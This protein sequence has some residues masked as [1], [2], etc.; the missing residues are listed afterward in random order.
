MCVC[1]CVLSTCIFNTL[2]PCAVHFTYPSQESAPRRV[3]SILPP[4]FIP[5]SSTDGKKVIYGHCTSNKY[6][7]LKGSS[8]AKTVHVQHTSTSIATGC[9]V[10]GKPPMFGYL[11]A[12]PASR[13]LLRGG[14][15][16][17]HALERRVLW[18]LRCVNCVYLPNCYRC[19]AKCNRILP[20][21]LPPGRHKAHTYIVL[22]V[23]YKPSPPPF[24]A[25]SARPLSRALHYHRTVANQLLRRHC[26]RR[27]RCA[28]RPLRPICVRWGNPR[29]TCSPRYPFL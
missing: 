6:E 14:N 15:V 7:G 5:I 10:G 29:N 12:R 24:A 20:R 23:G 2:P 21:P 11:S 4:N 19:F 28:P 27:P 1:V 25:P 16:H 18:W 13:C 26:C 17:Q 3:A 9:H 22:R 8:K